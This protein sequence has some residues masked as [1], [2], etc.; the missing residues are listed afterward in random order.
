MST[1]QDI[2]NLLLGSTVL[3]AA[4]REGWRW[5]VAR[6]AALRE[7]ASKRAADAATT[8]RSAADK[9]LA[10]LEAQAAAAEGR[11]KESAEGRALVA[12]ALTQVSVETRHVAEAIGEHTEAV[13]VLDTRTADAHARLT[14]DLAAQGAKL[15]ELLTIVRD[16]ASR[17]RPS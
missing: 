1:P 17:R 7:A 15:D 16:L 11:A 2:A 5:W 6:D 9:L 12:S 13:H 3:A 10:V 14:A 4:V 8:E